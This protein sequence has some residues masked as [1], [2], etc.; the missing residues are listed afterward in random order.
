MLR[1]V[2]IQRLYI[3][4]LLICLLVVG[5]RL[6]A[7]Q[8]WIV[9]A[10]VTSGSMAEWRLGEHFFIECGECKFA[11][12]FG[13]ET[14]PRNDLAVCPNCGFG[15]NK[16]RSEFRGRGQRV[17]ID[18]G[19]FW[20]GSPQRFDVVTFSDPARPGRLIVKRIVGLPGERLAIRGGDLFVDG[21][22]LRKSLAQYR[23]SAVVVHDN[24]H[25]A[26]HPS[27]VMQ[28]WKVDRSDSGWEVNGNG[29]RWTRRSEASKF[30]L[31]SSND[32]DW[33]I[34]D[35]WRCYASPYPRFQTAP[36]SDNLGY[37][38]GESRT[39]REAT[40]VTLSCQVSA[41]GPGR[42]AVRID[43]GREWFSVWLQPSKRQIAVKRGEQDFALATFPAE[44]KADTFEL[45]FGLLDQQVVVA[46]DADE[47]IREAYEAAEVERKPI[48]QPLGIR[49]ESLEVAIHDLLIRRDV[50]YLD[51]ANTGEP[52]QLPKT[53][54]EGSYFV[55]G[56]NPSLSE[57]SRHWKVPCIS[58]KAIRGKVMARK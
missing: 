23:P 9:P 33:L 54:P 43:D 29:F 57:D 40:D 53:I 56:D 22:R 44:S 11:F 4:F 6:I 3:S 5:F 13:V 21:S 28:R 52:W 42:L 50:Y 1:H 12:E 15:G 8:G 47:V 14:K 49:S 24:K 46:L 39:L 48:Q 18:R 41:L 25:L 20:F 38:Q 19:A 34:Y 45:E 16:Y 27:G 7:V 31:E 2:A 51:Y 35:H 26:R 36:I 32:E 17:L 58:L 55:L 10:R 30:A 37:N